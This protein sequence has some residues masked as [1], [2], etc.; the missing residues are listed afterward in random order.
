LWRSNEEKFFARELCRRLKI[1][2]N[3]DC[4]SVSENL[5]LPSEDNDKI[6]C[7]KSKE[8]IWRTVNVHKNMCQNKRDDNYNETCR[9]WNIPIRNSTVNRI[10]TMNR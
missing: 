9:N 5:F 3:E 8:K 1:P 7:F 10:K 4:A 2:I 6:S